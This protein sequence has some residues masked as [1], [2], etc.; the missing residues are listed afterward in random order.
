MVALMKLGGITSFYISSKS[1]SHNEALLSIY[2]NKIYEK[3][4]ISYNLVNSH[5]SA[6]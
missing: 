2:V 1:I 4:L 5:I 6:D 3:V